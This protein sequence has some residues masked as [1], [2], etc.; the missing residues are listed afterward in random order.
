MT[1]E[2][3]DIHENILDLVLTTDDDIITSLSVHSTTSLLIISDT[4]H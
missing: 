2:S 1:N 4:L 3:T